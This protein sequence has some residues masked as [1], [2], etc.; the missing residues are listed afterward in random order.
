MHNVI[1]RVNTIVCKQHW[2]LVEGSLRGARKVH[3]VSCVL[4]GIPTYWL[5]RVRGIWLAS[6]YDIWLC[7]YGNHSSQWAMSQFYILIVNDL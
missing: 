3:E 1:T 7:Y 4:R 6:K 5:R 2:E